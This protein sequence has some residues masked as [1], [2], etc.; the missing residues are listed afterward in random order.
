MAESIVLPWAQ[1]PRTRLQ[2]PLEQELWIRNSPL[3]VLET[4]AQPVECGAGDA[5]LRGAPPSG[6]KARLAQRTPMAGMHGAL[7]GLTFDMSG[8]QRQDAHGPE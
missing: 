4:S 6:L 2:Q 1:E 3:G 7:R 8:A 5:L